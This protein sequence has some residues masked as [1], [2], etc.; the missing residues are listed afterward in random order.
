VSPTTLGNVLYAN[1]TSNS[2]TSTPS[3]FFDST[4]TRLGIGCNA[5]AYRLDLNG[6]FQL[7]NNSG[8]YG[9]IRMKVNPFTTGGGSALAHFSEI[10]M[11]GGYGPYIRATKQIGGYADAVNLGFWTNA[12]LNDATPVER[13]TIMSVSGNVGIGCNAPASKLDI[14]GSIGTNNQMVFTGNGGNYGH[15]RFRGTSE[16]TMF[17]HD[18]NVTAF[19]GWFVGQSIS[20]VAGGSGF[21]IA[22]TTTGNISNN[23][24]IY[25]LS[26]TKIGIHCN[27]PPYT[28]SVR[29]GEQAANQLDNT[30]GRYFQN[31]TALTQTTTP[32]YPISIYTDGLIMGTTIVAISDSR[33]KENIQDLQDDEALQRLRMIQPKTYTYKDTIFRG[34]KPVYGFIAQQIREVLPY[35]TGLVKDCVPDIYNLGDRVD[36]IVT[37]RNSTFSF[38]ESSGNVRFIQKNGVDKTIPVEY[39]SSNQLRIKN[40]SELDNTESEIF[41]YGREVED[42][43]TIDKNAIFTVNVA[44]TQEL[45]RQLQAAKVQIAS[46]E[47]RLALLESQFAASQTQQ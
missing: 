22:R 45:D 29:A 14:N 9:F 5:P 18:S 13:I 21:A 2:A 25:M 37:L 10:Q 11:G 3:V 17:F 32:W 8:D 28:F 27:A 31:S 44:A 40:L 6:D 42:F 47:T 7:S 19:T 34:N 39:I 24:G 26:N 36:D 38:S 33:I 16:N 35:A 4:N 30:Q 15:I 1:G 12:A 43:H 46:L 20:S 41:V 23:N